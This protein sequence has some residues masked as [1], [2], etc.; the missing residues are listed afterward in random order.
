MTLENEVLALDKIMGSQNLTDMLIKIVLIEKMKLCI[1]SV[2]LGL[3]SF[4]AGAIGGRLV[5]N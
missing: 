1:A 4:V 2:G 5:F 3:T